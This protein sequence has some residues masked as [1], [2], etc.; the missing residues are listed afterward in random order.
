MTPADISEALS[1][2]TLR[3]QN[4]HIQGCSALTGKGWVA[5]RLKGLQMMLSIDGTVH[6]SPRCRLTD[7]M[8]WLASSLGAQ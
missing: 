5:A 1:L 8:D 3:L 4:W 2:T 6:R 7:G